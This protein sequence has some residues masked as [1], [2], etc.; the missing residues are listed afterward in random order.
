MIE[1]Q[2]EQLSLQVLKLGSD[3]E[4]LA[5]KVFQFQAENNKIYRQFIQ[6][7]GAEPAFVKDIRN[8]PF[9][10]I[11]FFKN[12]TINSGEWEA[13]TV[14][15]S[16]ATTSNTP[17]THYFRNTQLYDALSLKAF[18]HLMPAKV[19]TTAIFALL[20]NYLEREGS[21]LIHMVRHFQSVSRCGAGGFYL[22]NHGDLVRDV[23][24]ARAKNLNILIIGVSFALLDFVETYQVNW[25]E[26]TVMETGGMKGRG[27]ELTRQDLHQK[28]SK[29]FG[30][31]KIASEYGMTELTSQAYAQADGKLKC[32]P[33]MKVF[34]RETTDPRTFLPVGRGGGLNVIDLGNVHSCSFIETEDLAVTASESEFSVVGRL[35]Y[36]E[37]RGCNLMVSNL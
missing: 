18:N 32:P 10:P 13:K 24:A 9:L 7:L 31:R 2:I 11:Q 20:P 36:A 23:E 21:S 3:W 8:I 30:V 4:G 14:F 34:T 15:T 33:W 37:V 1:Q 6:N 17:S 27:Q 29:G 19:E 5:L 22:Y 26:V 35:D 12:H 25:P 16:S 28:L